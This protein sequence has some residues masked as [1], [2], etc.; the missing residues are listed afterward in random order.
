MNSETVSGPFTSIIVR[1][2]CTRS[3]SGVFLLRISSLAMRP[4]YAPGCLSA[5]RSTSTERSVGSSFWRCHLRACSSTLSRPASALK[6][7]EGDAEAPQSSSCDAAAAP[8]ARL[9][10]PSASG[11]RVTTDESVM[12]TT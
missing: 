3:F 9:C 4:G 5:E 8:A 11:S 2:T 10:R 1:S 6:D 7:R 12:L